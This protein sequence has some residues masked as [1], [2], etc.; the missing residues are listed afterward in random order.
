MDKSIVSPIFDSRCRN[1]CLSTPYLCKPAD[2]RWW[3]K[4]AILSALVTSVQ[5][6]QVS[7]EPRWYH[8]R[9]YQRGSVGFNS[10]PF[11][12]FLIT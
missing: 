1:V 6:E 12:V 8:C 10:C 5:S 11:Q 9:K 4:G 7:T 2:C 3:R